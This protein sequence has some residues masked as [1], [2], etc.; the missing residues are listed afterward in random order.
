EL[1]SP[2]MTAQNIH[3]RNSEPLDHILRDEHYRLDLCLTSRPHHL[4]ACYLDRW[5]P[6]RFERLGQT[7]LVPPGKAL[8]IRSDGAAQQFSIVC[9]FHPESMRTVFKP[10]LDWPDRA[11][12]ASLNIQSPSIIGLLQ[13]LSREVGYP[14]LASAHLV[15]LVVS[16]LKIELKRYFTHINEIPASG[17]L[18]PWRLRLIDERLRNVR[19]PPTLSE[20]AGLC[21]LSVRQLTHGFRVSRGC[22]IGDYAAS[23]RI[24]HAKYLLTSERSMQEIAADL[25]FS[26]PSSFAYAFRRA[27]GVTPREFRQ[28][29][30]RLIQ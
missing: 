3:F 27:T 6:H 25:G 28:R 5:S 1:R 22:S 26:A 23:K 17:G 12:E 16:Q 9:R 30:L 18:A 8:R 4:R 13:R 10:D 15:E 11:L 20:L 19:E 7:F 21:K 14:G 29:A 24:G 2:A